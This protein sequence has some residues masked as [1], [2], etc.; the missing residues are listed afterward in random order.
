MH[1][2]AIVEAGAIIEAGAVVGAHSRIGIGAKILHGCIVGEHTT[3]KAGAVIGSEGFGF[4]PDQQ[5]HYH[6]IP[7]LGIVRIEN[8][9]SIGA[10]TTWTALPSAKLLL[11]KAQ[12]LIT[13][14]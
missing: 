12:K 13:S 3:I 6:R 2:T 5:G 9:V 11:K 4:A 8:N 7:Q 10:N 1:P 14:V